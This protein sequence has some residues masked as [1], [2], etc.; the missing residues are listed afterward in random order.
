MV[1][2]IYYEYIRTNKRNALRVR[3]C[4][5]ILKLYI[6]SFSQLFPL[7][8]S[9]YFISPLQN[10]FTG[11]T[12]CVWFNSGYGLRYPKH[13]NPVCSAHYADPVV[14]LVRHLSQ[15]WEGQSAPRDRQ[16]SDEVGPVR[17]YD[18][19]T[20]DGPTAEDDSNCRRT[21]S[22]N[23]TCRAARND[24][25][26]SALRFFYGVCLTQATVS[27]PRFYSVFIYYY[28]LMTTTNM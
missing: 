28:V 4:Q 15:C 11:Y 16:K 20:D 19:D 24:S 6:C 7:V 26:P 10:A 13:H 25:L 27:A 8:C 17:C 14:R 5:I 21:R 12:I 22:M 1:R 9:K 2:S 18:D 3:V 23:A